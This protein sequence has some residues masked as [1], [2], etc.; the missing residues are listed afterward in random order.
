MYRRRDTMMSASADSSA[1]TSAAGAKRTWIMLRR[2]V[3][4]A[5][6]VRPNRSGGFGTSVTE[7]RPGRVS[8]SVR[9][10]PCVWQ[11]SAAA[12][13]RTRDT[14][15]SPSWIAAYGDFDIRTSAR[16]TCCSQGWGGNSRRLGG[17]VSGGGLTPSIPDDC[18]RQ[19]EVATEEHPVSQRGDD[20][21]REDRQ[22]ER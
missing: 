21:E 6:A 3:M 16:V 13:S 2:L 14:T 1:L 11:D 5:A 12:S 15:V 20:P 4:E 7:I 18:E 8:P 19:S 9:A 17:S 10:R 22:S